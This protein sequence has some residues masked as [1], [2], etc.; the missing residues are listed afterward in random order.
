MVGRPQG[1]RRCDLLILTD[2]MSSQALCQK[3]DCCRGYTWHD[4]TTGAYYK[5][6]FFLTAPTTDAWST[7]QPFTHHFSGVRSQVIKELC[8]RTFFSEIDCLRLQLCTP[9][10]PASSCA[11]PATNNCVESSV[12]CSATNVTQVTGS[13]GVATQVGAKLAGSGLVKV[14]QCL[15]HLLDLAND[16][17]EWNAAS[18]GLSQQSGVECKDPLDCVNTM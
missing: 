11:S 5:D 1:T 3:D 13:L 9:T 12:V 16:W 18:Y 2:Y 7:A 10:G 14:E 4:Q 15:E 17:P 6:C 8:D